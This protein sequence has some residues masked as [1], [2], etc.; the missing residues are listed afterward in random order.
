FW[1]SEM[2][3]D[4]WLEDVR[5]ADVVDALS[6]VT[7]KERTGLLAANVILFAATRAGL[8]PQEIQAFGI[9]ATEFNTVALIALLYAIV[10]YFCQRSS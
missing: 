8:V 5:E 9:R 4:Q 10:V 7:R 6:S 3:K 2:L 1:D